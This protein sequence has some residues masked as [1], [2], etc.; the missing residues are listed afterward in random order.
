MLSE[1]V[2]KPSASDAEAN[3]AVA[4]VLARA[5][6]LLLAQMQVL[7]VDSANGR[8][9]LLAVTLTSEQA[10][11]YAASGFARRFNLSL[12]DLQE[13]QVH[14]AL[15]ITGEFAASA[16]TVQPIEQRLGVLNATS[17]ALEMT[18][19]LRTGRVPSNT[20]AADPPPGSMLA[21]PVLLK[22]TEIDTWQARFRCALAALLLEPANC[23]VPE[24]LVPYTG[25]LDAAKVCDCI[26]TL[27]P[28]PSV[29]LQLT[30]LSSKGLAPSSR[31]A[32]CISLSS[33]IVLL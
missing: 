7:K 10:V 20:G 13:A 25:K 18:A 19:Q 21:N 6:R 31:Q 29:P 9:S 26:S 15:P 32:L 24:V 12:T 5:L 23:A 11:E 8:L 17:D 27:L 1:A 30:T 4:H 28:Y 33:E 2:S 16:P 22:R 14:A 3:R